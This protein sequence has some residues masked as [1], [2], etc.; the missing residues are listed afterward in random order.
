MKDLILEIDA[1]N[2]TEVQNS[3]SKKEKNS[4]I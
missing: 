4:T 3:K 1:S 2:D